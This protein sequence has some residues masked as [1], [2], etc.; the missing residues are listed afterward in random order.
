[1]EAHE[2]VPWKMA[3]VPYLDGCRRHRDPHSRARG[4]DADPAMA[5][6]VRDATGA[7]RP[8]VPSRE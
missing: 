2:P 5:E 1:V 6:L 4:S 7:G 3:D 8:V